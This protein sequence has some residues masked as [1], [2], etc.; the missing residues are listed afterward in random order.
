MQLWPPK[1]LWKTELHQQSQKGSSVTDKN[2]GLVAKSARDLAV[3]SSLAIVQPVIQ[4]HEN[5]NTLHLQSEKDPNLNVHKN[6]EKR[7]WFAMILS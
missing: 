7:S 5:L 6:L 4:E 3:Q 1:I 2:T